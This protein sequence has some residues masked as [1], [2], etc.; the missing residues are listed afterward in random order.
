MTVWKVTEEGA[1][2]WLRGIELGDF[3]NPFPIQ[4]QIVT[5]NGE[6]GV[7]AHGVVGSM[8][9]R[10]GDTLQILPKV[11]EANFL[12][13]FFRGSGLGATVD[14]EY[15]QF[16][17]YAVS[18]DAGFAVLAARQMVMAV[19][20][21]LRRGTTTRRSRHA[22]RISAV[23]GSVNP[24]RTAAAL[25]RRESDPVWAA[26]RVKSRDVPE[27]RLIDAALA[28]AVVLL[29]GDERRVALDAQRRWRSRTGVGRLTARDLV[30]VEELLAR[31]RYGG[32]RAYYHAAVTLALVVL[33]S[34]GMLLSNDPAVEG[35][36]V[37]MNSADVFEAYIRAVISEGYASEGYVVTKGGSTSHALY[38]DGAFT[39]QPDVVIERGQGIVLIA[40]AKYKEPSADDHYQV[41]AYLGTSRASRAVLVT[42]HGANGQVQLER[43]TTANKLTTVVAGLPMDDL[44][45]AEEFLR[46]ILDRTA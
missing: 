33:G 8:P 26:V 25:A 23:A 3:S 38:V 10:N 13:M 4:L 27:N 32:P 1:P 17:E 11:G 16:V 40:D 7:R 20:E 9:L 15:E 44:E 29:D 43:H 2:C 21:V 14:R 24:M 45:A 34:L 6:L 37:L 39:I 41:L 42:P 5:R 18:D 30:R 36:A 31:K 46:E 35:E 19:S 12:R 22:R 28:R